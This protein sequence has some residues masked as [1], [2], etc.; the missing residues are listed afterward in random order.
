M[1]FLPF[2]VPTA[3]TSLKPSNMAFVSP[4]PLSVLNNF[5]SA[6]QPHLKSARRRND[7][8]PATTAVLDTPASNPHLKQVS[9]GIARDFL[10]RRAVHTVVYYFREMHDSASTNW[11]LKFENF[12]SSEKNDMFHDGEGFILRML[13]Q[14]PIHGE[15]VQRHPR[16]YLT[17]RFPFTIRPSQIA[18]SILASRK[19]LAE[20]WAQD[21]GCV[22][23]DNLEMQRMSF[24]RLVEKDPRV[25]NSRR[26]LVF[27]YDVFA[28]NQTPMR[29]KNYQKLLVLVTQ[30]S[31]MR[32]M[33]YLRDSSNHDYMF[34]YNFT[35][36]YG[37][38]T[39]GSDFLESL[40]AQPV[41]R[42][43][44]PEHVVNPRALA[45]QILDLR[46][47]VADEWISI[48]KQIPEEQH[49]L[50]VSVLQRSAN[51]NFPVSG[52]PNLEEA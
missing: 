19:Q 17:R 49:A 34:L 21:L 1:R 9:A 48:M 14:A 11:L 29:S 18:Q 26:N 36:R 7:L 25:L 42:R 22:E 44:N 39:N 8:R 23:N 33:V 46:K 41:V 12:E 20:E 47:V 15:Y 13:Q 52:D 38:L 43:T 4:T 51:L 27:D 10:T 31:I 37:P 24:E 16:A 40:M 45:Y 5:I 28:N 30:H 3:P 32:L 50:A 6:K 35:A 2:T